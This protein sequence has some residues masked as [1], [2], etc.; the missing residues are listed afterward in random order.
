MTTKLHDINGASQY[1]H[2]PV[3]TLRDWRLKG[4]GPKSFRLGG[5]VMYAEEDLE[6]F[7]AEARRAA[8]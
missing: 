3:K 7:I 6:A 4:I 2:R 8:S 5:R 1:V